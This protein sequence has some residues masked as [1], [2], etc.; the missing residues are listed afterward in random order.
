MFD[1]PFYKVNQHLF[2]AAV[3]A[4]VRRSLS[5]SLCVLCVVVKEEKKG[6]ASIK[7]SSHPAACEAETRCWEGQVWGSGGGRKQIYRVANAAAKYYR[8]DIYITS[9]I[10]L[11]LALGACSCTPSV[12][13]GAPLEQLEVAS[14]LYRLQSSLK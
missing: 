6:P 10:L 13:T 9:L 5:L 3:P 1:V 8:R 4:R 11:Y 2:L 7:P 14:Q 12:I